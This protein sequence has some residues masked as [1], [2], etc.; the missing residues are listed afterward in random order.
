[1]KSLEV[2]QKIWINAG[3]INWRASNKS[4]KIPNVGTKMVLE[5]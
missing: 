3:H 5:S 4:K 2:D 1:M